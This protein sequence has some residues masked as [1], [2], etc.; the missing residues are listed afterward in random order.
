[1]T[2]RLDDRQQNALAAAA[3]REHK[4]VSTIVR[5]AL[6]RVLTERPISARAGHVK[7]RLRLSRAGRSPFRETLRRHNWRP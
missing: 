1:M 3:E 4:I 2:V 5:E 6:D 7:G